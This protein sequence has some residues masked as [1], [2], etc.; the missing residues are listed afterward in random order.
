M[1]PCSDI[2]TGE[3]IEPCSISIGRR[4][5]EVI[6]GHSVKSVVDQRQTILKVSLDLSIC[7]VK[8]AAV[9]VGFHSHFWTCDVGNA[10]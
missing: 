7:L 10:E 9:I 8:S 1:H 3:E 2:L 6:L 4:S 5:I